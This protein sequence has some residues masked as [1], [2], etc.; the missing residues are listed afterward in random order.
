[1]RF[2]SGLFIGA[3]AGA[4]VAMLVAPQSGDESRD[5]LYARSRE[6]KGRIKDAA[7]DL[8]DA[9]R[10]FTTEIQSSVAELIGRGKTI[11][12]DAR[13]TLDD[14]AREG[15]RAAGEQRESLESLPQHN[16]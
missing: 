7:D 6:T 15:R 16:T 3:L 8:T 12:E 5:L 2:L 13:A 11:V 10:A 14:A 1:M 9:A 4:A